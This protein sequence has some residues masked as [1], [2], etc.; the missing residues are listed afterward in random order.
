MIRFFVRRS[1]SFKLSFEHTELG[2]S[3][4]LSD[5]CRSEASHSA[6]MIEFEGIIGW[7]NPNPGVERGG[8]SSH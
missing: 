8:P 1:T 5:Y 3:L 6:D 4:R 2:Y 7:N